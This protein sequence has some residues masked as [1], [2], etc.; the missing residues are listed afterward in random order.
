MK[1]RNPEHEQQ[2][3]RLAHQAL[4][5]LPPCPAPAS[6]E[7][8]VLRAI[9]QHAQPHGAGVARWPRAARALLIAA[10]A[11]CMPLV[12]M[13]A[14]LLRGHVTHALADSSVGH[15]VMG[16]SG[17]SRALLG[18]GELAVRLTHLIPSDWLLGGL[19]IVS[20]VYAG[21]IALGYLLL[22]PTLPHSKAHSV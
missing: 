18:L 20:A 17:T 14:A 19:F 5:E 7:A 9:E 4:R 8:R 6:L 2:L 16:V 21:L 10:C 3:E 12:W 1:S 22:Y 11:L 15:V 13:L